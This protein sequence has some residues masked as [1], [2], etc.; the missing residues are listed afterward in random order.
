V[1][2]VDDAPDVI[3]MLRMMIAGE[4]TLLCVGLLS[5]ADRLVEEAVA[6]RPHVVLLDLTMPGR[7]PLAALEELSRTCPSARVLGFSGFDDRARV[8][9]VIEAGGW[10]LVSK[11]SGGWEAILA[12]IQQVARGQIV[13]PRR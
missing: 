11:D 1:L 9:A 5:S 6:H 7:D 10:G 4:P 2:C 13:R 12:A 8:N 3:R